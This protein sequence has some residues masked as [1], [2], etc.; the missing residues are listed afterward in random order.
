MKL[1]INPTFENTFPFIWTNSDIINA[2]NEL[3]ILISDLEILIQIINSQIDI[4]KIN[5]FKCEQDLL[6]MNM[7]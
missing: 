1:E 5:S 4:K 3:K 6:K 2:S 7:I